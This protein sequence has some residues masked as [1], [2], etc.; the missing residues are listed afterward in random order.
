ML[1]AFWTLKD[2]GDVQDSHDTCLCLLNKC[3]PP[4]KSK[5]I[6]LKL[7]LVHL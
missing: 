3:S 5:V 2:A 7:K 1:D 6:T 4:L